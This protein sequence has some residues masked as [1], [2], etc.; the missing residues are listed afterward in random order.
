MLQCGIFFQLLLLMTVIRLLYS[1]SAQNFIAPQFV[2]AWCITENVLRLQ[3]MPKHFLPNYTVAGLILLH[4]PAA[5][6][7]EQTDGGLADYS[8]EQLSDIVVTSVSRQETRLAQAPASIYV[9]SAA[10]IARSGVVSLPEALR[11]APNLQVARRDGSNYAITAR[12][13]SSTLSNKLLVL[14][15]GRSIYSPLFSGVFWD[16]H[17]LVMSDVERIE[18]ISGPGATIWGANAVNGVINIITR[19]ARD[20]QG[21]LLVARAGQPGH[22]GTLRYGGQLASGAW[23]RAYAKL[24][25][26]GDTQNETGDAESTAW[27]RATAGFRL[28]WNG[29]GRSLTLSGDAYDG[30]LG[31][32]SGGDMRIQGANLLGRVQARLP[33]GSEL[34]LQAYADHTRRDRDGLG[35]QHL[36][37]F[38]LEA[39]HSV[40]LGERHNLAWGGGYRYS[41]DR[42]RNGPLLKFTPA[43]RDLRWAN[44]FAQD[45]IAL[46]GTLRATAGVKLEHNVY[47]GVEVLPSLRLAWNLRPESLLWVGVSRTVRAPARIDRELM[48]ARRS[49]EM[50][51]PWVVAGGPDFASEV[52]RVLE[53]GYRVQPAAGLSF[54][55]TAFYSDY[56]RLRTLEPGSGQG[57]VFDNLG[58]GL[59]RGVEL[60]GSWQPLRSWSLAGGAVLQDIST[61]LKAGSLD[62]SGSAGLATND[63]RTYWSLRSSHDLTGTLRADLALRHVGSL[64]QPQ[65][66][67]YSELDARLAWQARPEL[68]LALSGRNLLHSE[69]AEFGPPGARQVFGRAVLL[70]AKVRF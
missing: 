39:Q 18:V 33:G 15:D 31:Q 21:A 52:A 24:T 19:S 54:S 7:Y 55:A 70:S 50:G 38:D 3:N 43:E 35:S 37:T 26:I 59:A 65:V 49:G 5:F 67:A 36:D 57:A 20:T 17:D 12:G 63:P 27:R 53:L 25:R 13:F 22:S 30:Q 69:H 40:R 62:T 34:R 44:L 51:T 11:L 16:S 6:A 10:D 41:Y 48:V 45:E 1:C 4:A 29:A 2:H 9:I 32:T 64:P 14:I 8:L 23:Y 61:G 66:P 60:W 58:Q 47:T 46:S 28:D 56:D 42:I 68:E